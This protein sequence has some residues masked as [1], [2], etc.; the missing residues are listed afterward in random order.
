MCQHGPKMGSKKPL[1]SI[2]E[3]FWQVW[4]RSGKDFGSILERFWYMSG[5]GFELA[6]EL[7]CESFLHVFDH[8][9]RVCYVK[10]PALSREASQCAGIPPPSVLDDEPHYLSQSFCGRASPLL[11]D[12]TQRPSSDL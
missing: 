9:V 2:L 12:G 8:F 1:A 11:E 4:G 7:A 6:S 10:T 3:R 5:T